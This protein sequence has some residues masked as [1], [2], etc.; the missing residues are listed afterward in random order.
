MG[1]NKKRRENLDEGGGIESAVRMRE[2]FCPTSFNSKIEDKAL[3]IKGARTLI[4]NHTFLGLLA[5]IKCSICSYQ[6][7]I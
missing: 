4:I 6:F 1:L 5:K 2:A 7:N 3:G